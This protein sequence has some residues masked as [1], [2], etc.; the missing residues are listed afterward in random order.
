M[1]HSEAMTAAVFPDW[2]PLNNA[3]LSNGVDVTTET[4]IDEL[5]VR[6]REAGV[7]VWALWLPSRATDLDAPDTVTEL[8][9]LTRDT[10]T[11]VMQATLGPGL[12]QHPGVTRTSLASIL[13]NRDEAPIPSAALGPPETLPG[14]SAWALVH[15]G[16]A[17]T[18]AWTFLHESD[19]GIYAVE[20]LTPWRRQGFARRLV[21]H[22][23]VDAQS[24]GARSASLQSTR[25][26]Q[27]L[28]ESLGFEPAGRYEEWISQSSEMSE[29]E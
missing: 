7:G 18:S 28:Y 8:G 20:T 14:L 29:E 11:L 10:T 4:V 23:L 17:V 13:D 25:M 5:A 12:R 6:Y 27:P 22:L 21:E 15:E 24:R 2:A 19:C 3:I 16:I 26:G 9:S 1:V